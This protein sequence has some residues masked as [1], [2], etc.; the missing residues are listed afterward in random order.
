MPENQTDLSP[1]VRKLQDEQYRVRLLEQY[2]IVENVPYVNESREIARGAIISP[3]HNKD[4]KEVF[5]DHT[6]W[7][8]GSIPH[9]ND[10]KSLR[11]VLIADTNAQ[12]IAGE[13]VLCRFSNKSKKKDMLANIY[14]KLTH[15]TK[16]LEKYAKAI[17]PNLSATGS[18]FLKVQEDETVFLYPNTAIAREGLDAYED[19]LKLGKVCI[20]GLGGTGSYILDAIAK[21]P[22]QEIHL[23]DDDIIDIATAYRMPGALTVEQVELEMKKTEYLKDTYCKMRT[24]IESHP[25]KVSEENISVLDGFDFVFISIDDGPS[26]KIIADRLVERNIPFIDVGLGVDKIHEDVSMISRVRATLIDSNSS[27][28]IQTLPTAAD[29]EDLIY[30]NIQVVEL[31]A[32]NAMLAVIM[33][34]QKIGFYSNETDAKR[35]RYTLAWQKIS[36]LKGATNESENS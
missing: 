1:S 31:N 12:I 10:G 19:K 14:N 35:L 4:G 34:K 30:E 25:V 3:Y 15:Y 29:N 9:T 22:V 11:D 13:K 36:H 18:G 2:I 26:R 27:S 23:F 5:G 16:K 20:I 7:F 33:Y 32:L 6:V 17:D 8:T 21:T 28:L 24:G